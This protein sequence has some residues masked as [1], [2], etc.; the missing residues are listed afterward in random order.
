METVAI[1]FYAGEVNIQT[2]AVYALQGLILSDSEQS[3]P[4]KPGPGV[5]RAQDTRERSLVREQVWEGVLAGCC[6]CWPVGS[7]H[8][9]WW[10]HGLP[11]LVL[12][13]HVGRMVE[14][15]LTNP[16]KQH[17]VL[18][19]LGWYPAG[20]RGTTS[21]MLHWLFPFCNTNQGGLTVNN[22]Q[23]SDFCL[24]FYCMSLIFAQKALRLDDASSH[25][26]VLRAF[27]MGPILKPFLSG[28]VAA[29]CG[30][31]PAWSLR[32]CLSDWQ[33]RG[34]NLNA[35]SG[36][37]ITSRI[38]PCWDGIFC[39]LTQTCGKSVEETGTRFHHFW[40]VVT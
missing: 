37:L 18:R 17:K 40:Q 15:N 29:W 4:V 33:V 32:M 20:R 2:A 39:V 9:V 23:P 12:D 1:Y 27:R 11:E 34:R 10:T 3:C 35:A 5:G 21:P 26:S 6:P 30:S 36:P 28:C 16:T 25:P 24:L 13:L 8:I 19:T 38:N 22:K 31:V 7:W 14:E